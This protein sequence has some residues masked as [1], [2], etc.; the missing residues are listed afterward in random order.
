MAT[1]WV[2]VEMEFGEAGRGGGE[3]ML[4]RHTI[5]KNLADCAKAFVGA[6]RR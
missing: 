3:V 4:Y 6:M 5:Y 1:T 2:P